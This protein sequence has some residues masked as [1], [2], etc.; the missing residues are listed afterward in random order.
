MF[1]PEAS[2]VARTASG[3]KHGFAQSLFQLGG[4]AGSALG[5]LLAAII[6]AHGPQSRIAW[7]AAIPL[8]GMG[9][10]ARVGYWYRGH[11]EEMRMNPPASKPG[12]PAD[13]SKRQVM[14]CLL[15]T[16]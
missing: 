15:Y 8:L 4:N 9:L 16:S 6:V 5:P 11:L 14:V 12:R 1:H 2:R 10:L 13:I 7:F 3:G